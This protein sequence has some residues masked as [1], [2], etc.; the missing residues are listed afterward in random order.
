MKLTDESPAQEHAI[1]RVAKALGWD[2]QPV[3]NLGLMLWCLFR[4]YARRSA[5]RSANKGER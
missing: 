4:Y 1:N 5:L 3:E 2:K